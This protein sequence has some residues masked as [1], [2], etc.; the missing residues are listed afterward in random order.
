[1]DLL[2]CAHQCNQ[3]QTDMCQHEKLIK[4]LSDWEYR[5]DPEEAKGD[6][7]LRHM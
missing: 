1:M 7:G 6:G 2:E 5:E 4:P 3:G